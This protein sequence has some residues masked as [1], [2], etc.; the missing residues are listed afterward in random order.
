M[1]IVMYLI[2]NKGL[3]RWQGPPSK[4][5]KIY[6]SADAPPVDLIRKPAFI[7][8]RQREETYPTHLR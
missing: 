1:V 7:G 8:K 2:F 5:I 6:Q 3:F 4:K